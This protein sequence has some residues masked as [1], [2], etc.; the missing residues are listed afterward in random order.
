MS[1]IYVYIG[2]YANIHWKYASHTDRQTDRHTYITLHYITLHYISLH[3][4]TLHYITHTHTYIYIHVCVII[5]LHINNNAHTHAHTCTHMHTHAHTCTHMHTHTHIYIYI[6]KITYIL[7]QVAATKQGLSSLWL[8]MNHIYFSVFFF[9]LWPLGWG[10]VW[11]QR[12]LWC[13]V[14]L[15]KWR[16][17]CE[18]PGGESWNPGILELG[19]VD[20]SGVSSGNYCWILPYLAISPTSTPGFTCLEPSASNFLAVPLC[21]DKGSLNWTDTQ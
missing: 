12:S 15:S 3:Y 16:G 9:V 21:Q 6:H 4:I 13:Y 8:E 7:W 10:T 14:A 2:V 5:F 19:R 17:V 18:L 20:S 1:Y 11:W